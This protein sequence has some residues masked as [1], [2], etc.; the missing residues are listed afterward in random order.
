MN[1]YKEDMNGDYSNDVSGYL[2]EA[3][4]NEKNTRLKG[5]YCCYTH[6]EFIKA[7]GRKQAKC[8]FCN[9]GCT[10]ILTVDNVQ[11]QVIHAIWKDSGIFSVKRADIK[12]DR[13]EECAA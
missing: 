9:V 6:G 11:E 10:R 4:I 8:P 7:A 13:K 5:Y 1:T 2:V 3:Y 12:T